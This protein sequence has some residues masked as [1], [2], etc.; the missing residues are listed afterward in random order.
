MKLTLL[1]V[2]LQV[3]FLPGGGVFRSIYQNIGLFN[4]VDVGT[5]YV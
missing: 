4:A 5:Y 1:L 3:R 2:I